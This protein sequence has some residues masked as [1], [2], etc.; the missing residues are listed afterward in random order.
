MR[1]IVITGPPCAGKS[2]YAREHAGAGDVI[3]D[4]DTIAHALG[5][6]H[7]HIKPDDRGMTV[8]RAA[9]RARA[10]ALKEIG[11]HRSGRAGVAWLIDTNGTHRHEADHVH[12]IDPGPD[13]CHMRADADGRAVDT[14]AE[15]NDWYT[16]HGRTTT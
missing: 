8:V 16:R 6:P 15:I 14:H 5:Y 3:L 2:T 1:L 4:L 9:L 7:E 10:S 11:M 12:T 13:V